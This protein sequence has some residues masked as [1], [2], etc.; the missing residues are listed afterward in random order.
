MAPDVDSVRSRV[1]TSIAWALAESLIEH[2]TLARL[3]CPYSVRFNSVAM[4][5]KPASTLESPTCNRERSNLP[6]V[7]QRFAAQPDRRIQE[8]DVVIRR[9]RN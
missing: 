6:C 3:A 2:T 1:Y 7:R 8:I 9:P 4:R 5:A